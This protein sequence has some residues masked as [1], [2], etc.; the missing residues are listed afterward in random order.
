MG[1]NVDSALRPYLNDDAEF[2]GLAMQTSARLRSV[3]YPKPV[4]QL[5]SYSGEI[6]D[7]D[8]TI[9]AVV[10]THRV[11]GKRTTAVRLTEALGERGVRTEMIGTGETS[12]FQGVR[13]CV[14]L[15]AVVAKFV[16]GE[17]EATILDAYHSYEPSVIVLEGQGSVLNPANPTGLELLTTARPDAVVMQHAPFQRDFGESDRFGLAT[18][19]RHIRVCELL[20]GKPV[21]AI[22]MNPEGGGADEVAEATA[23]I[24]ERFGLLVTDV[25]ADGGTALADRIEAQLVRRAANDA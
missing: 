25:L 9:V 20:S 13:S 10:G 24:R 5:R 7:I 4:A 23:R 1:I 8:A 17:I 11:V 6:A 12:W 14:L 3:G 21:I 15:D 22:T 2:P 16:A 19:D 18:L